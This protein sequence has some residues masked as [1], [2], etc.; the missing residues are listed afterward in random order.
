MRKLADRRGW[1]L[2]LLGLTLAAVL[3]TR[4]WSTRPPPT[5]EEMGWP[6]EGMWRLGAPIEG[7][8]EQL[9]RLLSLPYAAGSQLAPAP[10]LGVVEYQPDRTQPGVNLYLSGHAS[11]ALLMD[12][13][14]VL[15]HRWQ[16][17]FE[18]AFPGI[19][20]RP[21]QNQARYIR[22]AHLLPDGDLLVL[23]QAN[24]LARVDLRSKVV[25]AKDL[26]FY[27]DLFYSC[28]P[29]ASHDPPP[30]LGGG[31]APAPTVRGGVGE[32]PP[33]PHPDPRRGRPCA[34][35]AVETLIALHKTA[36]DRPRFGRE[37]V[38]NDHL[39]WL[40]AA[41]G[42]ILR[43]ISLLDALVDS[44][45]ASALDRRPDHADI[46]H[47]NTVT[48]LDQES[49]QGSPFAAGQILFSLREISLLGVL[50]PDTEQL[51][52]ARQGPPYRMQHEPVL[53]PGGR[54]LLFDNQ[55]LD[56]GARAIE[57]TLDGDIRWSFPD[58]KTTS[59]RDAEVAVYSRL[60]GTV[61]RL[62]N[63]NTLVVATEAGRAIEVT[64]DG[65][66]VWRFETPHRT[67][68]RGR[69]IAVLPQ[70]E[71]LPEPA[72]L[73]APPPPGDESDAHPP[74]RPVTK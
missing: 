51:V 1:L 10:G 14:G 9:A 8:P 57:I 47:A 74:R 28:E 3:L 19:D 22:R 41:T 21:Q 12:L 54:L 48:V 29:P 2:A 33:A 71:R 39:L 46:L 65:E 35:P 43:R 58:P 27:N 13:E 53:L 62:A 30:T 11:E 6:A 63:D 72:W 34:P 42:E 37:P 68:D 66:I 31:R 69:F 17:D 23:W 32:R 26:G 55:G 52:W 59:D 36:E 40:N 70:L 5:F 64:P 25:W 44:P 60:M 38:L 16:V 56:D 20:Q 61:Q 67:G 49:V 24:G 45:W 7:D 15:V 4:W 50:D 18:D 73:H